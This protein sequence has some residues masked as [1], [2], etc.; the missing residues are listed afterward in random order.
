MRAS[1]TV[2]SRAR[3]RRLS[4]RDFVAAGLDAY[5][6]RRDL[7]G[8]PGTS[9]LSPHLHFGE[10]DPRRILALIRERHGAVDA[11]PADPYVREL[12]WREFGYHLLYHVPHTAEEPLDR[13]FA[14]FP[15]RDDDQVPGLLRA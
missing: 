10:I 3:Q 2:G 9:R 15:W 12:L 13:R 7:P 5:R 1:R 8:V 4:A 11:S 14:R 6:E